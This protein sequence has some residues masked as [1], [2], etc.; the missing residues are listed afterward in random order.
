MAEDGREMCGTNPRSFDRLGI[1]AGYAKS[2]G[3]PSRNGGSR[4]LRKYLPEIIRTG[5]RTHSPQARLNIA[6]HKPVNKSGKQE[7]Q[8]ETNG[9][10][11]EKSTRD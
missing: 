2:L 1:R 3:I 7:E 5:F 10:R 6:Q 4:D 11:A 8:Q 9:K